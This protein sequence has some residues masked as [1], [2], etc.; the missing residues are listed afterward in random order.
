MISRLVLENVGP[1]PRTEAE[2]GSRLN[3]ITGDNGLGKTFILDA[4]WY[5]LT[6]TWAGNEP[7]LPPAKA[8]KEPPPAINY[9]V[10]GRT[11]LEA[12]NRAEYHFADQSW[13]RVAARPPIPGLVIYARI[14][15]GFSVWDP[16]RNYWRG[17]NTDKGSERPAS[18]QFTK[19][20]VWEGFEEDGATRRVICNGLLRDLEIWR[21]RDNGSYRLLNG[22]LAG[23]SEDPANPL[24][25]G[26]GVRVRLDDVRDIPTILM[27]YGAVPVTQAAAGMRRVLALAYLLVW[28]W[29]EH[30]RAAELRKEYPENRLILLFDEVEA[31]LH[32]K[33]Q[34]MFVPA[35]LKVAD[36][37][38]AYG[39]VA[40]LSND[41]SKAPDKLLDKILGHIDRSCQI[42]ATTHAPLVPASVESLWSKRTDKLF[43]LALDA[44]CRPRLEELN[45][46]KHGS[47]ANWLT[48][49]AFNVPSSYSTEAQKAMEDA[50]ALMR[51]Y[52][53][54]RKAPS[55]EVNPVHQALQATLGG[56]DE[57]WP[58]WIGYYRNSP[59][60]HDP[61]ATSP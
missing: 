43:D 28:A 51:Q 53:D 37:I 8:P 42:I 17:E 39:K 55:N 61:G 6:R 9:S 34:R 10:I 49:D 56:E 16:A 2:F 59:A 31:H 45:F 13:A 7:I 27:P 47:A 50:D 25:F 15:G 11:G 19:D 35:L 44:E 29:E 36:G 12:K 30:S 32:P 60:F 46:S 24:K 21:T 4:C 1:A 52:P 58:N 40:A 54:P 48:S 41:T 5:A 14:D 57:Y 38:L 3:L 26:E 20:Q 33:W 23:L 18:F 22:V